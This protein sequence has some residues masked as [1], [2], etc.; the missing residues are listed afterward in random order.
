M[1]PSRTE[2]GHPLPFLL[3]SGLPEKKGLGLEKLGS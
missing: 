3:G 1:S 2:V